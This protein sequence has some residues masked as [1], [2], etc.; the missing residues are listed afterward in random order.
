M[1][2]K[3]ISRRKLIAS[4]SAVGVASIAGCS[5]SDD[6]SDDDNSDVSF[7]DSSIRFTLPELAQTC[8]GGVTI[9][10]EA[11]NFDVVPANEYE[12]GKEGHYHLL[13][14]KEPYSS[15]DDIPFD[16]E[17]VYH[18]SD[19]KTNTVIDLDEGEYRL[20]IQA[21][22]G[23]HKALPLTND[24]LVTVV[25]DASVSIESPTSS[26]VE[27]PVEFDFDVTDYT[28]E[29]AD[30]GLKQNSGHFYLLVD[31]EEV[32]VGSEIPVDDDNVFALDDGEM[33]TALEMV[34]GEHRVVL[35]VGTAEGK[36]T[37]LTDVVVFDVEGGNYDP[38]ED[39]NDSN[40]TNSTDEVGDDIQLVG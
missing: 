26:T 39:A 5:S 3:S 9:N 4:F 27:S 24:V 8:Y 15:G 22:D 10:L 30:N 33:E 29:S 20:H 25:D 6:D 35:Q 2:Q 11:E 16:D 28:I 19:G 32:K 12:G 7:S 23:E 40:E 1:E 31:R 18:Y 38:S 36:A 14:D 21:G 37:P 13:I 34:D 17:N